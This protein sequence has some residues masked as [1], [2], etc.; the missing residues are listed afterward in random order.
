[1]NMGQTGMPE[2]TPQ[3]TMASQ[4]SGDPFS[5][6]VSDTIPENK[7]DLKKLPMNSLPLNSAPALGSPSLNNANNNVSVFLPPSSSPAVIYPT[8]SSF[9]MAVNT[10]NNAV[11]GRTNSSGIIG[12]QAQPNQ[13][14]SQQKGGFAFVDSKRDAFGFVQEEI[15]KK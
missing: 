15:R 10:S 7:V 4:K 1:M 12:Q 11:G 13:Q 5:L 3:S 2:L 9:N 8:S 6:L 14:Q